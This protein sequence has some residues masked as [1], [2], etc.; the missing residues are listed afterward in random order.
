[1][2]KKHKK[3]KTIPGGKQSSSNQDFQ[4]LNEYA[5]KSVIAAFASRKPSELQ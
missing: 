5:E 1:M 3:K 2:F 4:Y